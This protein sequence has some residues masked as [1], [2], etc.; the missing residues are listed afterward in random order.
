MRK[1]YLIIIILVA[2]IGFILGYTIPV[3]AETATFPGIEKHSVRLFSIG[4]GGIG[5]CTGT[6]LSN[7]E[8]KATVL[9]CKHCISIDEELF[10]ED[11]KVIKIITAPDNDLAYLIVEGKLKNK[12]PAKIA[13]KNEE[14]G[15]KVLMYG[16]PGLTINYTKTGSVLVYTRHWAFAKLELIGGCSGSGLFNLQGELVGTVWGSY[17]EGGTGGTLFTEPVGGTPIGIFEPLTDIK[18]FLEEVKK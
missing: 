7:D 17:K 13:N 8:T 11:K 1:L 9:T 12:K 15:S 6:V 16:K 2:I 4:Y 3:K 10:V 5:G 18:K 14:T